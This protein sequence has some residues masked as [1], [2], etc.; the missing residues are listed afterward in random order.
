MLATG[1]MIAIGPIILLY[2]FFSKIMIK[3]MTAGA[4]R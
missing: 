1:L 3:G 4:V 2:G